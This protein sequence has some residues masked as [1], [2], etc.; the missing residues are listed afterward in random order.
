MSGNRNLNVESPPFANAPQNLPRKRLYQVWRGNNRFFCGGRLV[1]G[2]DAAS[3]FLTTFLIAGPAITF[4][5]KIYFKIKDVEI[6]NGLT[7]YIVLIV[8]S[9]LTVLDLIFLVLTSAIDPGIVPRN[10]RPLELDET[11]DIR[12]SSVDWIDG[13]AS[14]VKLPRTK[15]VIVNGH[16]IKV[17]FC[18]TCF[19]YRPPRASH[20]SVCNNCV[21]RFDHHCPWV[22]QCIGIRNYRFFFMFIST[23]TMLCMYV[24]VLSCVNLFQNH[25]SLWKMIAH[26]YISDFLIV[27]C[28][29][30]VWFVGGLTAFHLY[31]VCTN[32]TT[33]ENFRYHYNTKEN[34]YNLG[35]PWNLK[36][37][38]CSS[39]P[40]SMN[41]FRSFVVEDEPVIMGS[42]TSNG[43]KEKI[44]TDMG[45]MGEEDGD[46]PLPEL[47]RN[48]DYDKWEQD[49]RLAYAEGP[50]PFDPFFSVEQEFRNSGSERTSTVSVLDFHCSTVE[51]GPEVIEQNYHTGEQVRES[52][53]G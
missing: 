8:G 39:L 30:A 24:F 48:F 12:P 15:D 4:C 31:L 6:V 35:K 32:Q 28:F 11:S 13:A 19:L 29:I 20:C 26:D 2:P 51:D 44:D 10:S 14:S 17:K 16:T 41:N 34:P 49:L 45:S 3:L 7:W 47:L 38:L 46:T 22:G 21:Q 23:S 27:Y 18:E 52:A 50:I 1:F 53:R 9:I 42:V 33:Y 36:E 43:P 40:H 37:T 5:V 25:M